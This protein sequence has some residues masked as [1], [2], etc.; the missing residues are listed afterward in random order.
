MLLLELVI[1]TLIPVCLTVSGTLLFNFVIRPK[2]YST[3][4]IALANYI[5]VSA[6]VGAVKIYLLGKES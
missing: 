2:L 6:V 3:F 1:W 5:L 4:N